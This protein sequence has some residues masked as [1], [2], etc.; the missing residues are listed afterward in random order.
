MFCLS[1][2]YSQS[3]PVVENDTVAVCNGDLSAVRVLLNDN[4]PDGDILSIGVIVATAQNGIV[5]VADDTIFYTPN[6]G[7]R[8]QDEIAYQVCDNSATPQCTDAVLVWNVD[9]CGVI[10]TAPEA[11]DDN[12][13][14]CWNFGQVVFPLQNDSDPENDSISIVSL[15]GTPAYGS[16]NLV[17]NFI[18]YTAGNV[19]GTD[20][21]Q[22]VVADFP[23]TLSVQKFDTAWLVFTVDSCPP[24]HAP[25]AQQDIVFG[26][27]DLFVQPF[28]PCDN[29]TDP[30]GDNITCEPAPF[31]PLPFNGPLNGSLD[32]PTSGNWTY[33]PNLNFNGV[34]GFTYKVCDDGIP[35]LCSYSAV[36]IYIQAVNDPPVAYRDSFTV[37]EDTR[38]LLPVLNNDV[39]VDGDQLTIRISTA[40]QHG[41]IELSANRRQLYYTPAAN[42]YGHDVFRYQ[43][44]DSQA[45]SYANAYLTILPVNDAPTLPD[46]T[47]VL[48]DQQKER[49]V[50]V[51]ARASDVEGDSFYLAST[52]GGT[53]VNSMLMT[54]NGTLIIHVQKTNADAC[55]N[56]SVF[57]KVCDYASCDTG[58]IYVIN[59]C[60]FSENMPDGFSPDGDGLN[61]K[62][63]FSTLSYFRPL[64]LK[65]FNRYGHPVYEA[66]N[67]NND[68]D[69]R[70]Q[71]L[72]QALPDGTYFYTVKIP[73]GRKYSSMLII[74]RN[75]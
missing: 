21:V 70:T 27:E 50:D 31:P 11:N 1:N 18:T 13:S 63:E 14:V 32:V 2:V 44:C 75:R 8:G 61:D 69:G 74:N 67:Y 16:V 48:S 4:D 29:D 41:T 57:Y 38:T 23:V 22:Y 17:A 3:A 39:D 37:L 72:N 45:C 19:S 53:N 62:L 35:S 9:T 71:N 54:E 12:V 59:L 34:D 46:T 64:E 51:L 43:A 40:P 15:I 47:I 28:N 58:I 42:Y 49:Y 66:D 26:I 68:W 65:V 33:H 7:F 55:G 24:N 6:A 73:D 52:W 10:N 30:D 25:S 20:S 36:A 56:D 5:T 60:P